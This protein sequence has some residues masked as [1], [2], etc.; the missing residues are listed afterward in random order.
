MTLDTS[1]K[2]EDDGVGVARMTE[3]SVVRF[4]LPISLKEE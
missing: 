3:I 2:E 4:V 1:Y